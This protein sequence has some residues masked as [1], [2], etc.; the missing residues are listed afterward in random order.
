MPMGL[1]VDTGCSW[2]SI[3]TC[4]CV[5]DGTAQVPWFGGCGDDGSVVGL[6]D[7]GDLSQCSPSWK[8]MRNVHHLIATHKQ[9]ACRQWDLPCGITETK[10][11]KG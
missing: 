7:L 10:G 11:Q 5:L 9:S 6:G 1:Q 8:T 4:R 2:S 3:S